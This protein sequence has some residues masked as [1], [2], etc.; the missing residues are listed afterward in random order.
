MV[1]FCACTCIWRKSIRG[2]GGRVGGEM[3]KGWGVKEGAEEAGGQEQE[4]CLLGLHVYT[5]IRLCIHSFKVGAIVR[6]SQIIKCESK[7]H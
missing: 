2:G 3:K 6:H 1:Y 4:H 5:Y 7:L